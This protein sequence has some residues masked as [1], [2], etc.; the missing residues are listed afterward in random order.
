M[1]QPLTQQTLQQAGIRTRQA[2]HMHV[3]SMHAQHN[4]KPS[5]GNST[6]V[7]GHS[8]ATVCGILETSA[9]LDQQ[10]SSI[11]LKTAQQV[12][13]LN[14]HISHT[15]SRTPSQR[16]TTIPRYNPHFETEPKELS[17][18]S[19]HD[20]QQNTSPQLHNGHAAQACTCGVLRGT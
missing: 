12:T 19:L 15:S 10:L 18:S 7:L 8:R 11:P 16:N 6:T 17:Y 5:R 13:H 4:R 20:A 1:Q 14:P 9:H 2:A 3:A